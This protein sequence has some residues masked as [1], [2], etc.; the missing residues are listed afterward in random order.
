MKPNT[1]DKLQGPRPA[2]L[3]GAALVSFIPLFGDAALTSPSAWPV[4]SLALC[5]EGRDLPRS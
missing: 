5:N 4:R 1:G 2:P 3:P